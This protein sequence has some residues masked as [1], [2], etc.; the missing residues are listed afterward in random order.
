M[1]RDAQF[2]PIT[3]LLPKLLAQ[4]KTA[5]AATAALAQNAANVTR[6]T[7]VYLAARQ[8]CNPFANPQADDYIALGN[9]QNALQTESAKQ[10]Q[11]MADSI[12]AVGAYRSL[13]S[14]GDGFYQN[15]L[16][17]PGMQEVV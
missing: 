6:L 4:R 15:L 13:W 11:L 16:Q 1:D 12:A 10:A 2:Q 14:Q 7:N 8:K 5:D 9:A 3:T 17:D